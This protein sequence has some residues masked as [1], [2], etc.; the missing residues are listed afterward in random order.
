M[1]EK[2]TTN[3]IHEEHRARMQER[4]ARDGLTSLAAHEVL[5][6]LLY[7]SIPRRDICIVQ[8]P[9]HPLSPAAKALLDMLIH[10]E[11]ESE[12]RT[13]SEYSQESSLVY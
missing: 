11:R 9:Q 8:N 13:L 3:S 4:V 2:K 12:E 7:F 10:Q 1:P 6:Y 5:E